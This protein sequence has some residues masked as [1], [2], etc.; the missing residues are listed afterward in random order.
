MLGVNF[1]MPHSLDSDRQLPGPILEVLFC[2][3]MS[4]YCIASY[5]GSRVSV[6]VGYCASVPTPPCARFLLINRPAGTSSTFVQVRTIFCC[7]TIFWLLALKCQAN[8]F[9]GY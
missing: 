9:I 2:V 4:R 5:Q 1:T 6:I 8:S 3:L 7:R